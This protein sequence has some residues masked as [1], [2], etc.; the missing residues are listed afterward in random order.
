M[1]VI[2]IN[3][4]ENIAFQTIFHGANLRRPSYGIG[5]T[6][7]CQHHV[8]MAVAAP[9]TEAF[10]Y[11]SRV[12]RAVVWFRD[13]DLRLE[14]HF[15]LQEACE[16]TSEALAPLLV[17]TPRSNPETLKAAARLQK[18]LHRRG[19][20]L[21]LRYAEDE[22]EAVVDFLREYKA[23]RVHVRLDVE[24]E[25]HDVIMKVEDAVDGETTVKTWRMELHEWD[26]DDE[27]TLS[28]LP[29]DYSNFLKWRPRLT[30]HICTST[31]DFEPDVILPGPN[32][33]DDDFPIEEVAQKYKDAAPAYSYQSDTF[34]AELNADEGYVKAHKFDNYDET[35]AE[36][37]LREFL[38]RSDN[39]EEPDAGRWLNELFRLG[40]LSQGR[41]FEIINEHERQNGR[42]W[43]FFYR[44]G[45]KKLLEWLN[46]REHMTL[47]ARRDLSLNVT[48]DGEHKPKFWRWNSL[49]IRYVEEGTEHSQN[50][51]PPLLLVHGFG[52]SSQHFKRSIRIL[53]KKYHVFALDLVGFG[54]SEKPP[55]QYTQT[56]WETNIFDFVREVVGKPVFVA[57]NSIGKLFSSQ[58]N[59][60]TMHMLLYH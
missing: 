45:A 20:H 3:M 2:T 7:I 13:G 41:M 60:L 16:H 46:A 23:D 47:M 40:A 29:Y 54:R 27:R 58:K 57:G 19:S 14:D 5:S 59:S 10:S 9:Q 36:K 37:W 22:S 12:Q 38:Q 49:L 25:A 24:S 55:T 11:P 18:E 28:D 6:S 34:E 4:T 42:I 48:V 56:F 44:E 8:R 32:L 51:K 52:A 17:V 43:R 30:T 53:K 1:P 26:N 50:G 31:V 39:Y 21:V 15:G 33:S 35:S